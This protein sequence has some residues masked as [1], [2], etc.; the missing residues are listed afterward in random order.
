MLPL[1]CSAPD[2]LSKESRADPVIAGPHAAAACVACSAI[3]HYTSALEADSSVPLFYAK[4]A[5]AYQSL[6]KLGQA[7][8]DLDSALE[9]DGNYSTG[10]LHRGKLHRCAQL[11]VT[12]WCL[13]SWA[14]SCLTGS[15]RQGGWLAAPERTC[16]AGNA[17]VLWQLRMAGKMAAVRKHPKTTLPACGAVLRLLLYLPAVCAAQANVQPG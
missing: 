2:V 12:T 13:A 6:K 10:Y 5:A 4:R 15:S 17:V 9:V 1:G 16:H 14:G 8:R 3:Q 11:A 7:L